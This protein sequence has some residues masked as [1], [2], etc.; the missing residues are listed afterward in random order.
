VDDD[1]TGYVRSIKKQRGDFRCGRAKRF[2]STLQ[3]ADPEQFF[4]RVP[5]K[6]TPGDP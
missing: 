2:A 6:V 5:T 3:S 4:P 1:R